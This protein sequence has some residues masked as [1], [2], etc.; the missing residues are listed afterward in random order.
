MLKAFF[1][2]L[3]LGLPI[4]EYFYLQSNSHALINVGYIIFVF[5][6]VV[7]E[8]WVGILDSISQNSSWLCTLL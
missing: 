4:K 6:K 7:N 5:P 1:D 8:I 3:L 2:Y